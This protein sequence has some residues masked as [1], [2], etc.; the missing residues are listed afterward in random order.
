MRSA[1]AAFDY[2][3]VKPVSIDELTRVLDQRVVR[4]KS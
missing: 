2:H 4:G 1:E 3:L